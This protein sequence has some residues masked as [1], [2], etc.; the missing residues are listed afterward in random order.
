MPITVGK[1]GRL[2]AVDQRGAD[3]V[4]SFESS[5][6]V[7]TSLLPNLLRHTWV[8]RHWR[9]YAERVI[10]GYAVRRRYWPADRSVTITETAEKIIVRMGEL[11]VE[12]TRDPFHLRYCAGD[13]E[14][15]LEEAIDGGLSWSYWDYSVRYALSADDHFYGMGQAD[16]L[17]DHLDLDHRGHVRDVWNHHS[18]PATT[19]FPWLL[20]LRGYGLL[21]DNPSRAVWDLG[22]SDPASFAYHARGGGL[23]YYIFFGPELQRVLHTFF[24]LT[25]FPPLPPRWIFGLL[26]SRYGYRNRLE[27]ETV[28]ET[29]RAKRLPCDALILDVF[30]F[31][32]MGDLAFDPIDWPGARE[33]ISRLKQKGFRTMVIEEPYVTIKSR[34]Y[35]EALSHEYLAR[36]YDGTAYTF[37]FWPGECALV[38]FSNP[39]AREWWSQKHQPLLEL[40][41]DGWWADLNEPAK[42]FQDMAHHGGPAASV[43]NSIALFMQQAIHDAHQRYAP[44]R[45]LFILS[46]AAFPGSQRY[47]VAL[48]SGDV[49]M[50]FASLRKQVAVGLN[51]GLAGIPLWGTDIGGFGFGGKC[52]AELYARWFEFGA[53]CPLCRP[54]GDQTELR[55]PW[56][57]G[58]EIEAIC[59]KYLQLR[60]RLLPYIYSAAREACTSGIPI[61]RPLVL[62]YPKDPH[63]HNLADEYLFGHD[64]LVA[65]ILDEGAAER[66]VYLPAGVWIDF[67]TEKSCVGPRFVKV[68]AEL[69]TIPLFIRQGAIIPMGPDVQYSSERPLDPLTL[70]IYRGCDGA[71][72][73]YEDDG[74]TSAY[75][76]G[77][78]AETRFEI[79][80]TPDALIC[81]LGEGRGSF[82]GHQLPRTIL[83]NIHKQ[84]HVKGVYCDDVAV[85]AVP[86][87]DSLAGAD[88]GWWWNAG[89]QI[90]TIKLKQTTDA[91]V[92]KIS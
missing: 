64:I 26:Q 65:P 21:V 9:L 91:R 12:A 61:M 15:F 16:Q 56:Q 80:D 13:G 42:H 38:D 58:S 74:E 18:P 92:I 1:L 89:K 24:E 39:S 76:N 51:V 7:L 40:G 41:I 70:E 11:L 25:G 29:F 32:E 72:T 47:G 53:F 8:P 14:P 86:A 3:V 30:W 71:F 90:L 57:F 6:L 37:D 45:R 50:T 79:T 75:L 82:A 19:I 33:M 36:H 84:Q 63:V 28:A 20:S 5:D 67:W 62:A 55:E 73:L 22:H 59:R 87:T 49:D 66:T 17:V 10:D 48:W 83:L 77:A 85:P 4:F 44:E 78:F 69:D 34:S 54:H 81:S 46:R 31:K 2:R 52:S 35:P 68:H 27:L 88:S 43:H 23:Q 60:Y